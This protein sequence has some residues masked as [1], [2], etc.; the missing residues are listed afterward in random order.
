[1]VNMILNPWM[2]NGAKFVQIDGVNA[3]CIGVPMDWI[4]KS[5]QKCEDLVE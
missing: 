2:P 5:Q 1:M 4:I 3:H